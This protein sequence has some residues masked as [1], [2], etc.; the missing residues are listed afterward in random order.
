MDP[1]L[2]SAVA[3]VAAA[4]ISLLNIGFT[5]RLSQKQDS[6][7]WTRDLLPE[8]VMELNKAFHEEYMTLFESDRSGMTSKDKEMVGMTELRHTRGLVERLEVFAT[9]RTIRAAKDVR[10]ALVSM[11]YLL[12]NGKKAAGG[13]PEQWAAYWKYAEANHLFLNA[14]RREMGLRSAPVPPGL[15]R[16]R[17]QIKKHVEKKN[18]NGAHGS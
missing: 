1:A 5:A 11:R 7:K 16:H 2:L 13:S 4:A 3:A 14:A 12:M 6:R 17:N 9:P 8:V 15:K 10:N 18:S